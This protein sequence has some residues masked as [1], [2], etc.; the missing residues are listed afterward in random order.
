MAPISGTASPLKQTYSSKVVTLP[1][2]KGRILLLADIRGDILAC[3]QATSAAPSRSLS[4][5]R[6]T[7]LPTPKSEPPRRRDRGHR[8]HSHGRL[9][10]ARSFSRPW[11]SCSHPRS[12]PPPRPSIRRLPGFFEPDSL[13]RI[14]DKTLKHLIT[15]SPTIPQPLRTRLLAPT[16]SRP[17]LISLLNPGDRSFPLS[18]FPQLLPSSQRKIQLKVPTFAVYGACEDVRIIEKC[19]RACEWAVIQIE[20]SPQGLAP[21]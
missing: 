3:V 18:Q 7:L 10:C 11:V 8:L 5:Q 14:A 2:G 19:V 1:H 12:P 15:Y 20:L 17:N 16:L 13:E 21:V 4:P 9:W 6:L